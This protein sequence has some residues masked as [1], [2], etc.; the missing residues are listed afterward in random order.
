MC[1]AVPG[2]VSEVDGAYATVDYGGVT[3]RVNISFLEEV[4][5][6]EYVL[7]HIGYAI[8]KIDEEEALKTLQIW[9]EIFRTVSGAEG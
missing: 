7:V 1:Y 3:K 8:Q 6:G 4:K 2:R 9:E 5:P